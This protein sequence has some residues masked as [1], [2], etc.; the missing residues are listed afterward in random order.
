MDSRRAFLVFLLL[1][2]LFTAPDPHP[3]PP[4]SKEELQKQITDEQRAL[5]W[6]NSSRYGDLNSQ[7]DRWLPLAGLTKDDGY[8]WGLLPVVQ[9]RA[10]KQL[11]SILHTYR[12]SV[13]ELSLAQSHDLTP[14]S[15]LTGLILPVYRNVT[16]R[17]RGDWVRWREPELA[18]R[19]N[20]NLTS[21]ATKH[22][23]FTHEFGR[24]I[25]ANDGRLV[26]DFQEEEGGKALDVNG[27]SVRDIRARMLVEMNDALGDS[28]VVPLFG[29]HFPA[30]GA[31]VLT[32]TSEKFAGITALPHFA[33]SRDSFQTSRRLLNKTLS[34]ALEL[35]RTQPER[36]LPWSSLPYD[37]ETAAFPTPKCE[38]IVYIQQHPV[39]IGA[40]TAQTS[41]LNA[42]EN[43]LR[44]PKGA[45]IPNP[46]PI[47]MSAAMI[48][49]DCGFFL[50]SKGPPVYTPQDE[51]YL[52]GLKREEYSK[53]AKRFIV[54]IAGIFILH[55]NLLMRQMKESSTPSTR[56]R[57]SFF[58]I[59]VMSMGDAL[60]I[61]FVLVQLWS[62]ASFLLITATSFLAFFSI[63]FLGMKFQI[64]IWTIQEPERREA[65]SSSG[66]S[67]TSSTQPGSLPAPATNPSPRDT[68]A[69]PTILPPDQDS[70]SDETPPNQ[71]QAN[72]EPGV[73]AGA[74]YTRFYFTL[75]SLFFLSS[76][77]TFWPT[78]LAAIYAD[79]LIFI[80]LSFWIPQ[81]YRNIMRNCRKALRWE[82]VIGESML[83]IFPFTYFYLFPRNA[84]LTTFS[85]AEL[86]AFASWIWIQNWVLVSQDILG[87]RFFVPKTW[88]PP[89]YDY[90]PILRDASASGS[91]EDLESGDILPLSSLRAEQRDGPENSRDNDKQGNKDRKR[92]VFDCAICM[93][94]IDV[95]VLLTPGSG[96]SSSGTSVTES[97]TNLLSRRTYMVTPCRHIFHSSC[98]E[99]WMRLRLQCPI[100]RES[101]PPV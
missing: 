93:Q 50:E 67:Q 62:E 97:A 11:H 82:F 84:V 40:T 95:P 46:P 16:G 69:T 28:W 26:L 24:N 75:F 79:I 101:I 17:V 60:L 51:L 10:R 92:K 55:I 66:S 64:E 100:C 65:L 31:I 37:G 91:G 4:V 71:R 22:D 83:R 32:T 90:H 98:L 85:S 73:S 56:S 61:S 12:I 25:T 39:V 35:K 41:I 78:R 45:P 19:P 86:F 5:S 94:D 7:N 57:V 99:T 43:E 81:I 6:L 30:T 23:Y 87:P 9:T 58:T 77:A 20:L 33:L 76:W 14:E 47:V 54:I 34:D 89:A 53:Y 21:I 3:R 59:A 15:N 52:S 2:F 48:S 72:S 80:Y 74:M 96:A 27:V 44:F 29:I 13:P 1:F 8:A 38:Y 63:S 18:H 49:P 42:I 88:V 70:P 68:G 36:Y